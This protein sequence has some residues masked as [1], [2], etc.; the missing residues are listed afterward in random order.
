MKAMIGDTYQ[1]F[2]RKLWKKPS[3]VYNA[4]SRDEACIQSFIK[5]LDKEYGI[6]SIG[7][8]F[9][10]DYFCFQLDYWKNMDTRF[11]KKIPISWFIGKK[12]FERWKK[13]P[14]EDL[15]HAYQTA[16]EFGI[17]IGLIHT[18][19]PVHMDVL[20]LKETEEAE[21]ARFGDPAKQLVHCLETTTLYNHRSTLCIS[22]PEKNACKALLKENF[23][24]IY[25]KRGYSE[26]NASKAR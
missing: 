19:G 5:L 11:G 9:V 18:T 22:C 8:T 26:K 15:W 23:Y 7:R 25:L 13:N 24:K 3:F 12:A 20:E 14:E 2:I 6:E 4:D 21:K 16:N 10:Y 17:H 1:T